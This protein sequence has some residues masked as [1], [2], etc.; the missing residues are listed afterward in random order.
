MGAWTDVASSDALPPGAML[1]VEVDG[2]PVAVFNVGGRYYAM[3]DRCPHDGGVLSGGAVE[4]DVVICPRHGASF[5]VRT[6]KVL[7]PP[8][9]EDIAVLAVRVE[10]GLVQVRDERWD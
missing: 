2:T 8:A 7:S 10:G 5:C 4:D 9:C 3:E 6:G 1:S